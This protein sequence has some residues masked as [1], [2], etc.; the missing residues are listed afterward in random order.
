MQN[1]LKYPQAQL[2][3]RKHQQV[4]QVFDEFRK[5]WLQLS[6]EEF[7]R[8][9]VLHYLVHTCKYPASSMAIEKALQLNDTI[10]RFDIVVYSKQLQPFLVIECKAPYIPLEQSVLEQAL[11]YNLV[12]K[13]P[14]VMITNGLSDFI[15]NAK[16]DQVQLPSASE[17]TVY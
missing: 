6:P 9:H 14:F 11:R 5:K 10:K 16:G 13:A 17:L 4:L 7:V 8:Q 15:F 3:T 1:Q 12:L 2:R